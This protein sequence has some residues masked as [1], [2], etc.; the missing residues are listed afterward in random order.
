MRS[1]VPKTPVLVVEDDPRRIAALERCLDEES[2]TARFLGDPGRIRERLEREEYTLILLSLPCARASAR[3]AMEDCRRF[4]QDQPFIVLTEKPGYEEL[5]MA[6]NQGALDYIQTPIDEN[7]VR[8]LIL[9][10]LDQIAARREVQEVDRFVRFKRVRLEIPTDLSLLPRVAQRVTNDALAAGV[11]GPEQSYLLNLA[12]YEILTNAVEHG[13]LGIS[14]DEKSR[15]IASG[16]FFELVRAR[17][18]NPDFANRKIRLKYSLADYG[19]FI[20]IAD[21]GAGFDVDEYERRVRNR[22]KDSYHGRGIILARNL[23]HEVAFKG[24]G[25]V[26]RLFL[27]RDDYIPGA[28]RHSPSGNPGNHA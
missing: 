9:R 8:D 16:S 21:E 10:H 5:L 14:Y 23:L 13:N 24:R 22:S 25:N 12:L 11:I 19:A 1:L 15:H 2:L 17:S 27:R 7:R 18:A 28:R 3:K 6:M 20:E 26:V 4:N